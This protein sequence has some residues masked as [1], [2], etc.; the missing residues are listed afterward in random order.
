MSQKTYR[1]AR[2][3]VFE[4]V[5]AHREQIAKTFWE[6]LKVTPLF[7]KRGRLRLAWNIIV[8]KKGL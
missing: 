5:D 7:G 1:K 6:I 3:H 4:A 2:R 8:Y